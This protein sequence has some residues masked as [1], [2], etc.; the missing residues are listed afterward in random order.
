MTSTRDIHPAILTFTVGFRANSSDKESIR[1]WI[2]K[3]LKVRNPERV[4]KWLAA[5]IDTAETA[6][7]DLAPIMTHPNVKLARQNARAHL[8]WATA[9]RKQLLKMYPRRWGR[10][11]L[12]RSRVRVG[13]LKREADVYGQPD[14]EE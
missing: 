12:P 2:D 1:R 14:P 10:Q 11:R 8:D 4:R 7:L 6:L 9:T 3:R 13:L 5:Q